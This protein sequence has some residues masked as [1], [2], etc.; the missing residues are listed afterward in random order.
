MRCWSLDISVSCALNIK[1]EEMGSCLAQVQEA[2]RTNLVITTFSQLAWLW[3]DD[4]LHRN[5]SVGS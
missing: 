4:L 5:H 1:E 2:W 3:T